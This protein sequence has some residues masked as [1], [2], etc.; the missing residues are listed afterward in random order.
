M[1][2]F[3]DPEVLLL[4]TA[5]PQGFTTVPCARALCPHC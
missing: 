5:E 4:S 3:S 1:L 2:I